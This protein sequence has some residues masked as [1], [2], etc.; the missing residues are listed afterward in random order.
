MAIFSK[1]LRTVMLPVY[2]VFQIALLMAFFL[3]VTLQGVLGGI[4]DCVHDIWD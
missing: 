3:L 1:L 4:V 2:A